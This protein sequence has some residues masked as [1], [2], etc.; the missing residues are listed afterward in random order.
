M[1]A[2]MSLAHITTSAAGKFS[3]TQAAASSPDT[4]M[5]TPSPSRL[6]TSSWPVSIFVTS[7]RSAA[8]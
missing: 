2:S 6:A 4:A 8:R 5:R 3:A 1:S 7:T